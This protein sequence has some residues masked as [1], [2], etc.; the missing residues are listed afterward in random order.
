MLMSLAFSRNAVR[1]SSRR[2]GGDS[3]GEKKKNEHTRQLANLHTMHTGEEEPAPLG[4]P[5]RD[6]RVISVNDS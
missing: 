4:V 6:D 3:L 5:R 2:R 1:E